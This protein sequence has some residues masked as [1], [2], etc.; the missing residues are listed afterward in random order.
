MTTMGLSKVI[1]GCQKLQAVLVLLIFRRFSEI[2]LI[3]K[4]KG[5]NQ[6]MSFTQLLGFYELNGDSQWF[7]C[8]F[9]QFIKRLNA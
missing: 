9:L 6:F 7:S 8:F 5:L 1:T 4:S 2:R 3:M